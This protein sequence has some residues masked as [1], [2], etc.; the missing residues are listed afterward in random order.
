LSRRT[1]KWNKQ[2]KSFPDETVDTVAGRPPEGG[3]LH[4]GT[5]LEDFLPR[6]IVFSKDTGSR[7]TGG[8]C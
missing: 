6:R 1:K 3:K 5:L 7:S 8:S 2:H 4:G